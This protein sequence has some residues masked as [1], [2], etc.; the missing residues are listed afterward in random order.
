MTTETTSRT[1]ATQPTATP[2]PTVTRP[3]AATQPSAARPS[4]GA[5][6]ASPAPLGPGATTVARLEADWLRMARRP[7]VVR[8]VNAWQVV[9]VSLDDAGQLLPFLGWRPPGAVGAGSAEDDELANVRLRAL[10]HRAAADD[11]AARVV[12]HRLLPGLVA[13]ARRRR[14]F[15]RFDELIGMAWTAIRT[16]NQARRCRYVAATL[17]RDAEYLTFHRDTRRMMVTTP[18]TPDAFADRPSTVALEP[19]DELL[20]LLAEARHDDVLGETEWAVL[21]R[22]VEGAAPAEIARQV[23]MCER[24]VR[25]LK[26]AALGRLRQLAAAA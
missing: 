23:Q 17:L 19:L 4:T 21:R 20:D 22:T 25:Y 2:Q 6:R 15:D 24:S 26:A 10:L 13:V 5:R 8:R 14:A 11:L 3:T 7:A 1:A 9:T 12:L 18:L 16:F